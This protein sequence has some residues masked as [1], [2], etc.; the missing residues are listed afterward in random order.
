MDWKAEP[1]SFRS[2]EL[3]SEYIQLPMS[4]LGSLDMLFGT[5]TVFSVM[6]ES[7]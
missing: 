4:Y 5:K 1:T 3:I 2:L 6:C 7:S